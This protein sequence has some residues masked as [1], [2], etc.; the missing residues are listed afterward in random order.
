M[1]RKG[2]G[3]G[4]KVEFSKSLKKIHFADGVSL[5]VSGITQS[6]E[7]KDNLSQVQTKQ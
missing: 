5:I 6:L 7:L 3:V 4:K 1:T 2:V